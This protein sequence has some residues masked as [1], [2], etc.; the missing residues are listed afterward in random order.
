MDSLPSFV[1]VKLKEKDVCSTVYVT[2]YINVYEILWV[3]QC[4]WC[5][6]ICH[7]VY[8]CLC[9][10]L[11]IDFFSCIVLLMSIY[12][13]LIN[14]ICYISKSIMSFSFTH[15]VSKS[16]IWKILETTLVDCLPMIVQQSVALQLNGSLEWHYVALCSSCISSTL[17]LSYWSM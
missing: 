10:I 12:I 1:S 4:L 5:I 16:R 17:F 6:E 2:L 8:L 7:T 13:I 14:M 3:Y 9:I 15:C 11:Y